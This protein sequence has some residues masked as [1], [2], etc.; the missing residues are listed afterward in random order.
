MKPPTETTIHINSAGCTENLLDGAI[1]KKMAL[2]ADYTFTDDPRVADLIVYNTCAF[3]KKQED[4]SIRTIERLQRL[5]KEGARLIVCGCIVRINKERLDDIFD[6]F[7][8]APTKLEEFYEVIGPGPSG[9]VAEAHA[10]PAEFFATQQFGRGF[11]D[12][13]YRVKRFCRRKLKI[14]LL[15][16]FDILDFLGDVNTLFIR[17]ARGCSNRY[18][19]CAV[20]FAQ[21]KLVSHPFAE[22]I[23]TLKTGPADFLIGS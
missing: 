14:N 4:N 18:G 19:Y 5:K 21:G 20:R 3:K 17:M 23:E 22:I 13:V 15:P 2:S 8:F 11:I 16:N 10:I 6:G 9:R 1:L 12:R 7:S